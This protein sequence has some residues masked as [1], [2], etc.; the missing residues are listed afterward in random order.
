LLWLETIILNVTMG[1]GVASLLIVAL[2]RGRLG[3]G[4]DEQ[5]AGDESSR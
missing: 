4:R 3:Y 5:V 2:T 1:F